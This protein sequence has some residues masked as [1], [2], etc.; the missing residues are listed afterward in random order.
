MDPKASYADGWALGRLVRVEPG[1]IQSAYLSGQLLPT[2]ILL[3][4][5]VPAEVPFVAGVIAENPATPNSHVAILARSWDIP[6]AYMD[7]AVHDLSNFVGQEVVFIANGNYGGDISVRFLDPDLPEDLRAEIL[8]LKRPPDLQISP[9]Q[10]TG[11]LT[12]ELDGLRP[13][14]ISRVGGKAAHYGLLREAI[15]DN[16][17]NGI[18]ITFDLW[19]EFLDQFLPGRGRTLREEIHARLAPFSQYPPDFPHLFQ[20]LA[21]IRR[22]IDDE[23]TFTEVQ[24]LEIIE[25]LSVFDASRKIRF[26]SSTN[27]EDSDFF[28]GAG[29]YDSRSGCLLDDLDG[30][31]VGP[32][33]CD[34]DQANER[35]VFRAI[36]KVFASFYF[37]NA[38]LERLRHEVD[39]SSAGMAI[40]VHHSFPDETELANGVAVLSPRGR[41]RFFNAEITTQLGAT[42]V[43][44]P[45]GGAIPEVVQAT[46]F[47]NGNVSVY[48]NQA[49]SLLR[50]GEQSVMAWETDYIEL[51]RLM[52]AVYTQYA[53]LY[54][55][56]ADRD[57]DFEFKKLTPDGGLVIKQVRPL[58]PEEDHPRELYLMAGSIEL[59]PF[60]GEQS[61]VFALHRAKSRFRIEAESQ[62]FSRIM[63]GKSPF[64]AITY[65]RP[66]NRQVATWS[67]P[68]DQ[69]PGAHHDLYDDPVFPGRTL[70]GDSWMETIAGREVTRTLEMVL[71][72]FSP[73]PLVFLE[74][75]HYQLTTH[76]PLHPHPWDTWPGF[77]PSIDLTKP[78]TEYVRLARVRE[79]GPL[80]DK[81][82]RNHRQV[83]FFG[84]T[85]DTVFHWPPNPSGVI[86]GYTAPLLQWEGTTITG[87]TTEPIVLKSEFA[88]TYRP[89]HHNFGE[90]FVFE[91]RLDPDVPENLLAELEALGI[92]L[93]F[94]SHHSP[95]S[96]I[97]FAADGEPLRNPAESWFGPLEIDWGGGFTSPWL[98]CFQAAEFPD[99]RHEFLDWLY[100]TGSG[101]DSLWFWK[102]GSP[103]GWIWTNQA[104]FPFFYHFDTGGWLYWWP[105][106]TLPSW[107][108]HYKT[109]IWEAIP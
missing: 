62:P 78:V 43:T 104:L 83:S 80:P 95:Y 44:N 6:Y 7:G 93:I 26:R 96:S 107:W 2:D 73:A 64:S 17:R 75:L 14:D 106:T 60:Q 68:H 87:L 92:Q 77:D 66:V 56:R 45:S 102:Y 85:V 24:R 101:P 37:E 55:D 81:A 30:D 31:E 41:D 100:I 23:T 38:F 58:P 79:P 27:V 57:L 69:W 52:V 49:S 13:T 15:P 42:S 20:E 12:M 51:V 4:P 86:A 53:G 89:D 88:Q 33:H 67:P 47:S 59:E 82:I 84:S 8:S 90:R 108:Y 105:G 28:T 40:L 72:P 94:V 9:Y 25:A 97:Q 63:A 1:Q 16:S 48:R 70:S 21:A 32:S 46:H 71:P 11:D 103:L 99:I 35:G 34:P 76:Y 61:D 36:R 98:G 39:E 91:P 29:L 18:A 22:I 19:D 3:T 54:P 5:T 109:G 74:D 10:L 65:S 50:L